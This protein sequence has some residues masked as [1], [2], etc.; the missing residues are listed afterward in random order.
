MRRITK[1]AIIFMI[2][3][4]FAWY[5]YFALWMLDG[6]VGETGQFIIYVLSVI[7]ISLAV[8]GFIVYMIFI[9]CHLLR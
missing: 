7:F 8:I 4:C 5:C 9:V 1:Y 3:E 6:N 2:G